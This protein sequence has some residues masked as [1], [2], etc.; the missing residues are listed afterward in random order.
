MKL[1]SK[2]LQA[3]IENSDDRVENST[4]EQKILLTEL[5]TQ[6]IESGKQ[7]HRGNAVLSNIARNLDWLQ[8]LSQDIKKFMQNI[9]TI[10]CVTYKTVLDIRNRLQI[11]LDS[12]V[13]L[14]TFHLEDS[15]GRHFQIP[16]QF[17]NS[18]DAFDAN[19]EVQFR[20]KQGH[21]MVQQ[22]QYV[23]HESSANRD[24]ERRFPWEAEFLP[25]QRVVVCMLFIDYTELDS[26]P[27]CYY[28]VENMNESDI[29]WYGS[30]HYFSKSN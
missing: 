4:K 5:K 21:R 13:Q 9:F 24:I 12:A 23:L 16:L 30:E 28:A 19:M 22:K 1:N 14:D 26:C 18:W 10:T 29:K 3:R 17:V 8:T 6:M 11:Q 25:G 15:L 27:N 7:I 20:D 2:K